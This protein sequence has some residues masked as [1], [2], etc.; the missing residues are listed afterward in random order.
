MSERTILDDRDGK[1]RINRR[2]ML[3]LAAVGAGATA[4]SSLLAACGGETP[5]ATSAPAASA[6]PS[7]AASSAPASAAASAASSTS[8]GAS[9][10]PASAAASTAASAAPASAA[11][12]GATG[13]QITIYWTKPVTIH[14]LFS[15][16]GIEQGVERQMFG[17]LM[18]MTDKLIPVPDLAE[19]V[20][21]SPD[22]KVWTFT[23]KKGLK[24]S[25]G[26]PLTA[27]DVVFTFERAIDKRSASYWSSRLVAIDGAADFADQKADKIKG[28][29]TPD[30]YT[31][32][33]TLATPD[34]VWLQTISDFS[35][36]CILPMHALKDTPPDQMAK[37]PFAF[38]PTPS[39]GAFTFSDWKADQYLEIKRNETYTGG[40]KAKLDKIFCKVLTQE[41]VGLAQLEKGEIDVMN[42]P[43]IEA[44][45]L[46]KNPNL[47]VTSTPAPAISF[48]VPN[49]ARPFFKDKRSRQALAYALDREAMVK[50][51]LK[52]EAQIVNSTII[53]PDWMGIPEGLNPYKYDPDKAKQLLKEVN[54]DP[55]QKVVFHYTPGNKVNDAL[56]PI[57]QQQ[58]KDIG[59]NVELLTVDSTEGTRK[60]VTSATK[61]GPGDFDIWLNGGG[62]FRQDPNVSAKYLETI[63]KTPVGANYTHYS[64]ARV[65]ELFRMG[66]A[67]TDNAERKKIYTELA[68][69]INDECPWIYLWSPNSIHAYNKR[70]VGFKPPSYPTHFVWNAEEWSVTS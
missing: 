25:D 61:D 50:E 35:G 38:A 14:P 70:L 23:L 6:R 12:S 31:I 57:M 47:T 8:G 15:T 34:S 63:A 36:L 19:K 5:T 62:V 67:T 27:K 69:I 49:G 59:M 37:S 22:A 66:R 55:N 29:E 30:D 41:D 39:A 24:F 44:D 26:Q 48:L 11:A 20:E 56:I 18:R 4:L 13:G 10:A 28:L 60:I 58:F 16:A 43:I 46:R 17:A 51:I 64:N 32:K 40:A 21:S 7:T 9:A 53:G 2:G 45:R 1:R 42:V 68:K 52:G 65:D 33:M 3:R 54:W